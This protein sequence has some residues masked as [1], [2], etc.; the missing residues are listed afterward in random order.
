MTFGQSVVPPYE[1]LVDAVITS[2]KSHDESIATVDNTT[3]EITAVANNG[4]TYIDVV[5]Q[6]GTAVVKVMIGKVND[7][8]EA[9][10]SPIKEK[11]VTPPQPILNLPKAILGQW[12]W[13]LGGEVLPINTSPDSTYDSGLTT[14]NSSKCL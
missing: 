1:D 9:E 7:G 2:Y 6:N 12:I 8:D 5:T 4:R 11:K 14:P 13:D 10:V 3:G